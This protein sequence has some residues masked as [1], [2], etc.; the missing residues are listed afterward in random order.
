[1]DLAV[2]AGPMETAGNA[3]LRRYALA[4]AAATLLLI[5]AGGFVTTTKTGDTIPHWPKSWGRMEAG[6]QVELAHRILGAVVGLLA[7]GLVAW[8]F[9]VERR[10]WAR[11]LAVTALAMVVAQGLLGGLRI[12]VTVP[13][14]AIV[15]AC[16]AQAVFCVVAALALAV[17]P[18]WEAVRSAEARGAFGVGAAAAAAAYLQLVAGAVTRHT[19]A[20][21]TVHLVGAGVVLVLVS[22]FASR[23]ML[24][25]L[26]GGAWALLALL[27]LQIALGIGAWAIVG[28][29]F[30]RSHRSPPAQ[31]LAV[32][33]HVAVG[34]LLLATT[35]V[36]AL[37]CRRAV[38]DA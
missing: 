5:L 30:V 22:V 14:V 17:S 37:R 11:K 20:G 3:G 18:A 2:T 21:L 35:L 7:I 31:I 26:S 32:T 24:T 28:S 29:G 38:A 23:L 36:T 27:G 33:S 10:P 9:R 34:A 25:P 8:T 15:H 6:F 13:A 1:V 19:G 4:T 12:Y 16:F